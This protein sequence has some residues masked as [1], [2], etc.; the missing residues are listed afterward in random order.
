MDSYVIFALYVATNGAWENHINMEV[1]PEN[2]EAYQE[3]AVQ[4]ADGRSVRAVCE[5]VTNGI[6]RTDIV[7]FIGTD[8]AILT[9]MPPIH[10]DRS[11]TAMC[12]DGGTPSPHCSDEF[13]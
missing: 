9:P 13:D 4:N 8:G 5:I 7:T 10:Y 3:Q 6:I 1:S 12:T 11:V 2:C